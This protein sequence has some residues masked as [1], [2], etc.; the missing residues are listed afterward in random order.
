MDR[1]QLL[2]LAVEELERQKAKVVA[3]IEIVRSEL[4]KT[5]KNPRKAKFSS[6]GKR[7]KRI[8]TQTARKAHSQRMKKY[9]SVKKVRKA[10]SSAKAKTP[11]VKAKARKKTDAEKKALS[12]KMKEVWKKKKEAA[13]KKSE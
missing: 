7:R 6:I 5:G 10:K 2:E 9:R 1:K 4:N 11:T 12:L 13:A 3:D 8:K